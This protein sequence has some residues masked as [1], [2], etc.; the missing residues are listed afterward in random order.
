MSSCEEWWVQWEDAHHGEE[1]YLDEVV[2]AAWE[3]CSAEKDARIAELEVEVEG[4]RTRLRRWGNGLIEK[5]R[6]T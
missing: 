4:L 3:A 1:M 2:K 6:G 5:V